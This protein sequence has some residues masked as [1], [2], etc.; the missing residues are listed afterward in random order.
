MTSVSHV[1]LLGRSHKDQGYGLLG[2]LQLRD[3]LSVGTDLLL[4]VVIIDVAIQ[5]GGSSARGAV[6]PRVALNNRNNIERGGRAGL[7]VVCSEVLGCSCA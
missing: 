4:G 7:S 3:P 5:P 1:G 2:S 6:T